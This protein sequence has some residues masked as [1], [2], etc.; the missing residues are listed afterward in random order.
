MKKSTMTTF[1]FFKTEWVTVPKMLK[2]CCEVDSNLNS[3]WFESG[4]L[5]LKKSK[6]SSKGLNS[7][8]QKLLRI[9]MHQKKVKKNVIWQC[10]LRERKKYQRSDSVVFKNQL[11]QGQK[12]KRKK[13]MW[14][15]DNKIKFLTFNTK[16]RKRKAPESTIRKV[17][18]QISIAISYPM[19]E[20]ESLQDF[21][22]NLGIHPILRESSREGYTLSA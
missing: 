13:G 10:L 6:I 3:N 16:A 21:N 17:L 19:C 18:T 11:L 5:P 4:Q 8:S 7:A 22:F 2:H 20:I 1:Y 12:P 15:L 14:R 9:Q